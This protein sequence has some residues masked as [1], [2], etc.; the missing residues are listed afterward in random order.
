M[1]DRDRLIELLID[2]ETKYA[3]DLINRLQSENERLMID[4]TNA[5]S[6][7]AGLEKQTEWFTNIGKLYSEIKAEA[8]KEC[9]DKIKNQI[10]NNSAISAEWLREYLNNLLKMDGEDK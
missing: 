2:S 9:I 5:M 1:T 7:I 6:K 10:K 8:Y 3:L 4:L